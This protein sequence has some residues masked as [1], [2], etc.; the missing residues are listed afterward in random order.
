MFNATH[1]TTALVLTVGL[2]G[3]AAMAGSLE[4]Q[5]N[6]VNPGEILIGPYDPVNINDRSD[7]APIPFY[8]AD[9]IDDASPELD[10]TGVQV[11]H[12]DTNFYIHHLLDVSEVPSM[13]FGFRHNFFIDADQ[14]RSTG[15]IGDDG[16]PGA[17]DGFLSIGAD[18]LMQ[19]PSVFVFA[20][21][22]NQE[23]FSWTQI[24]D[25]FPLGNIAWDDFPNE[26]IETLIP[27]ASIGNP[28]AFD[29][30]INGSNTVLEDYYPDLGS[31]GVT[32]DYFTY[33]TVATSIDGDLNSD[34][35]VGIDDL[36]IVLGAW[37]QAV[38]AGDLLSGDPSGDGFVGI[39]D[40]NTVLGNWNAGSPPAAAV[41]EPA[42]LALLGLGGMALLKRR[43]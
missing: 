33:S 25:P 13:F 22:A 27:R 18:Y 15:F 29:F 30:V 6:P 40:L 43:A 23:A 39:D 11:A 35:F 28:V 24:E 41:P 37:N 31:A 19:G 38:T 4:T 34:G 10:Y 12:D 32:G 21:G 8:V 1:L 2:V 42:T 36:N 5:S 3:P 26:D 7:W 14:D 17:A 9:P 20:G 16:D